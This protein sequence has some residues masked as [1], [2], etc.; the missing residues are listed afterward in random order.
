MTCCGNTPIARKRVRK[1]NNGECQPVQLFANGAGPRTNRARVGSTCTRAFDDCHYSISN[2]ALVSGID[3]S[4]LL[5]VVRAR[6]A[7][8]TQ[9][10][11]ANSEGSAA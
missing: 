8:V 2:Y 3:V 7:S 5:A 4:P 6:A 9:V 10:Y 11:R 1:R